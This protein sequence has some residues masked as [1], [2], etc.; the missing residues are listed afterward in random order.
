[1][2]SGDDFMKVNDVKVHGGIATDG[3]GHKGPEIAM[4]DMTATGPDGSKHRLPLV[5]DGDAA[6]KL[7][8]ELVEVIQHVRKHEAG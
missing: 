4:M 3:Y 6:M 5:I 2:L 7:G 8:T 1:M